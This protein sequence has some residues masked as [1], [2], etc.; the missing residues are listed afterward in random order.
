MSKNK[1]VFPALFVEDCLLSIVCPWL[2][3]GRVVVYLHLVH[4]WYF[5]FTGL[6]GCLYA[7]IITL[8]NGSFVID[9]EIRKLTCFLL[10]LEKEVTDI[11]KVT[12]VLASSFSWRC[13]YSVRHLGDAAACRGTFTVFS[14]RD[15]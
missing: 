14:L 12:H 15:P 5:C 6:N 9:F 7:S 8:N 1:V 4:V 2:L 13:S 11:L 3:C 10:L